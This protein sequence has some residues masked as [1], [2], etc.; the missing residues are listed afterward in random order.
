VLE[1]LDMMKDKENKLNAGTSN[2]V[3]IVDRAFARTGPTAEATARWVSEH[4]VISAVDSLGRVV[5]EMSGRKK[6]ELR[7]IGS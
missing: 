3:S 5:S 2:V 6:N 7:A 1:E 4:T